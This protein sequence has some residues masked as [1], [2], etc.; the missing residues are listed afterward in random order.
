MD[1]KT[2]VLCISASQRKGGHT[3]FLA[4]IATEAAQSVD[5]VEAE[6]VNLVDKKVQR[7]LVC[8]DKEGRR[9]CKAVY[10]STSLNKCPLKGDDVGEIMKKVADADGIIM[11]SPVYWGNVSGLLKDFMDR[12]G[13][14]KLR[15]YWLRDKVGGALTVAAHRNGGQEFTILA[16]ETFFRIHGMIIVTDGP[17]NEEEY[18]EIKGITY[19]SPSSDKVSIAWGR[20]HFAG[21]FADPFYGAIKKDS[22]GI[23]IA[24]GLG[25]HVAEVS[26][27]IK[28]AKP[29]LERK[30]YSYEAEK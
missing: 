7:C 17:P 29:V 5:G 13:G 12:S 1:P 14:L 25:R 23:A 9:G 2:K 16:I 8:H 21:A 4:K 6:F 27:W 10:D 15:R 30:T 24:K 19:E 26:K 20:S 11:A 28:A 3:E 18:E 22:L